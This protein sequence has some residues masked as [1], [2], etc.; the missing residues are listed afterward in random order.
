MRLRSFAVSLFLT[1]LATC[2]AIAQP[3]VAVLTTSEDPH[4]SAMRERIESATDRFSFVDRTLTETAFKAADIENPYNMSVKQA[5]DLAVS[6]GCDFVLILKADRTRRSSSARPEY[7]ES[8]AVFYLVSGKT[9][10]LV[11]WELVSDDGPS[12]EAADKTLFEQIKELVPK[13]AD[14]AGIAMRTEREEAPL[15]RLAEVPE[16]GS[17]DAEEFKQPR[18]YKRFRPKYTKTAFMYGVKASVEATVDLNAEGS[19]ERVEVTKWA[20]Y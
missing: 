20:G 8:F 13:L 10:R 1:L 2:H 11:K 3:K 7:Y 15:A 16:P 18:P 12:F 14:A 6:I 9:G 17:P 5:S 4:T 19:I